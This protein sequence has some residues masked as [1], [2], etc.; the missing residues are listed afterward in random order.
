MISS[1][2]RPVLDQE[3]QR[4]HLQRHLDSLERDNFQAVPE[5]DVAMAAGAMKKDGEGEQCI[6]GYVVT[7]E[8]IWKVGTENK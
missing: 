8:C 4:R 6:V 3:A 7:L 1:A 5:Y 2:G